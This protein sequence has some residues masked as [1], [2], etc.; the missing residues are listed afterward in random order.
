MSYRKVSRTQLEIRLKDHDHSNFV[1]VIEYKVSGF[2]LEY[3]EFKTGK[4][5]FR[6]FDTIEY[7]KAECIEVDVC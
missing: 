1:I 3:I 5:V 7:C 6:N 2:I 4:I